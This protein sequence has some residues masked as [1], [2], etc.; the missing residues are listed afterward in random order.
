M[1]TAAAVLGLM[2][3][4]VGA[5]RAA[6]SDDAPV[7]TGLLADVGDYVTAPVRWRGLEW[8]EFAATVALTIAAHHYDT[9]VRDHFTAGSPDALGGNSHDLQDYAPAAG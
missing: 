3:G 5:V 6:E 4:M 9:T 1:R 8:S 2:L 7:R